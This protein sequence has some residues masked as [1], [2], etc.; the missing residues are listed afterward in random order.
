MKFT[1]PEDEKA[2]VTIA[3]E[4]TTPR[5][6]AADVLR[7]DRRLTPRPARVLSFIIYVSLWFLPALPPRIGCGFRGSTAQVCRACFIRWSDRGPCLDKA[8]L[9]KRLARRNEHDNGNEGGVRRR[10]PL[11]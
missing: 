8:T 7:K 5:P 6:T 10:A 4:A 2:F 1:S 3:G 9:T 11:S